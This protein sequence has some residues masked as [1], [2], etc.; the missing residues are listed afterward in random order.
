MLDDKCEGHETRM[1]YLHGET[2][3]VREKVIRLEERVEQHDGSL[4]KGAERFAQLD[5]LVRPRPLEWWKTILIALAVVSPLSAAGAM[6]LRA[7]TRSE[8]RELQI[9]VQRVREQQV[10]TNVLLE[11]LL[12]RP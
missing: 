8:L 10:G 6:L 11:S 12:R 3:A 7:P 9:E 4:A 1:E 5:N 2:K